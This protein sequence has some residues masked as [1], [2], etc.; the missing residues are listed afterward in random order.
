MET[1][2]FRRVAL[3]TAGFAVNI[4]LPLKY[5]LRFSWACKLAAPS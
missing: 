5:R 2:A 4:V 1:P 3:S